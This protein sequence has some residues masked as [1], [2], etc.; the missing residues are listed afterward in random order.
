M[1]QHNAHGIPIPTAPQLLATR[2]VGIVMS[3]ALACGTAACIFSTWKPPYKCSLSGETTAPADAYWKTGL[4]VTDF[5]SC[6]LTPFFADLLESPPVV[7]NFTFHLLLQ[8][9]GPLF[10]LMAIEGTRSTTKGPA[11][12]LAIIAILGQFFGIS[13]IIPLLW[14]SSWLY[15]YPK[16][17]MRP[18]AATGVAPLGSPVVMSRVLLGLVLLTATFL[19]ILAP[20]PYMNYIF[21]FFQF[22]PF[23]IPGLWS[24]TVILER[25]PP[26]QAM[27]RASSYMARDIYA[28][29]AIVYQVHHFYLVRTF[30]ASSARVG[31]VLPFARQFY[32]LVAT[33]WREQPSENMAALFILIECISLVVT[34]LIWVACEDGVE[35]LEFYLSRIAFFGPGGALTIFCLLRET[36]IEYLDELAATMGAA[37]VEEV[38]GAHKKGKA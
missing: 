27:R 29:F 16:T 2:A 34:T 1:E 6:T 31:G 24:S 19:S 22:L 12:S 17:A 37:P 28:F 15:Y 21:P 5:V 33:P 9:V 4:A 38:A 7:G 11:S 23:V 32:D 36:R 3:I 8:I 20:P 10:N 26:T 18:G 30:I 13:V 14:L 25:L 35:G